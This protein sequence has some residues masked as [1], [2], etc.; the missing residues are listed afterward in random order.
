MLTRLHDRHFLVAQRGWKKKWTCVFSTSSHKH[1]MLLFSKSCSTITSVSCAN[2]SRSR[3]SSSIP[4]RIY[5]GKTSSSWIFGACVA[6][7]RRLKEGNGL[8]F[9]SI[10]SPYYFP[11]MN[12]PTPK[13]RS[14]VLTNTCAAPYA[15]RRCA[16]NYIIGWRTSFLEKCVLKWEYLQ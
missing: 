14:C 1:W 13:G 11:P 2:N 15:L 12:C 5:L 8:P 9:I 16:S 4:S 3:Y 10:L 6:L 7:R